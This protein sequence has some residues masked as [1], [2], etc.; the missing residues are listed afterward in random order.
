MGSIKV[1]SLVNDCSLTP[2]CFIFYFV[3]EAICFICNI[4]LDIFIMRIFQSLQLQSFNVYK[5][6]QK[7]LVALIQP[8]AN[9]LPHISMQSCYNL[10]AVKFDW[11]KNDFQVVHDLKKS[12]PMEQKILTF[13]FPPVWQYQ[14]C[15]FASST[16]WLRW[17]A[18]SRSLLCSIPIQVL[19]IY[20]FG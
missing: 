19:F 10:A 17:A 15:L 20:F 2:F 16:L 11:K 9:W 4:Q 6:K 3:S 13:M 5:F 14:T 18:I 8:A 12:T 7:L 1:T